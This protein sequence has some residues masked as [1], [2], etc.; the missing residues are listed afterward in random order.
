MRF[1]PLLALLFLAACARAPQPTPGPSPAPVLRSAGELLGLTAREL[2]DRFGPPSFQVRDGSGIK[3]QWA[4]RGCVLDA[5]LYPPRSG[6]GSERVE[7]VD[8]RNS[9][10]ADMNLE[11]CL[12]LFAS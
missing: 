2:G 5:Y 9:S 8:A 6:R 1:L 12:A 7:H 3:L 11:T 10:G 4:V